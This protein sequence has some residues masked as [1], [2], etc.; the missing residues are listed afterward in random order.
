[1]GWV[2]ERRTGLGYLP[3]M[4][5]QG[6]ARPAGEEDVGPRTPCSLGL[7]QDDDT[8]IPP[9]I[10]IHHT[11]QAPC[12]PRAAGEAHAGRYTSSSPFLRVRLCYAFA[13]ELRT[14]VRRRRRRDVQVRMG[15]VTIILSFRL[16]DAAV[17]SLRDVA[18][19]STS[20]APSRP[21]PNRTSP[22]YCYISQRYHRSLAFRSRQLLLCTHCIHRRTPSVT[23]FL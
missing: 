7:K 12:Y 14:R 16:V 23:F 18:F 9:H 4:F 3:R 20:P 11:R 2:W 21:F 1:M 6:Q 10:I 8:H 17:D 19:A 15:D 22:V 5:P 13:R